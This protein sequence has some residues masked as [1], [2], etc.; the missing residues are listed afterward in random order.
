VIIGRP[1]IDSFAV[2]PLDAAAVLHKL[3]D[4]ADLASAAT[5]YQ[6]VYGE[7]VD[8]EDFADTLRDLGFVRTGE[9]AELGREATAAP[10]RWGR[11]SAV[12]LSVPALTVYAL[13]V[14]AAVYFMVRTPALRPV[15]STVYFSGSL[16]VVMLVICAAQLAGIAVHEW[17][18]VLAGRRLGLPSRLTVGRRLYF[19]VF[20]TTLLGLM[21][22]P[23]RKRILPFLAGLIADSVLISILIGLAEAGRAEG[24]P[25]WLARAC[26]GLAYVTILRVIWQAMI[27]ME[28]DL[29]HVLSSA[30]RCPDLHRM[31]VTYLRN[32]IA[33]L[34]GKEQPA[35]GDEENWTAR[36]LRVVRR[37]APVVVAGSV[38]IIG[39]AVVSV[40]P[41][42][43][44][45]ALRVYRGVTAGGL[46]T[47][48][49]WD[50]LVA[51]LLALSPFATAA[52][53][54][55]RDRRRRRAASPS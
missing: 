54:A 22:V 46:A 50:A 39:I 40:V 37:Y 4:G 28:T 19:V 45:L 41:A 24:W 38:A 35:P 53:L 27:F 8:I 25:P 13:A 18:H 11:L 49:F 43:Y 55:F 9:P 16:L 15:P 34:R 30:V 3:A 33:R 52:A 17:F 2:F 21:G 47:G 1:D 26:V 14:A 23:S 12:L 42:V 48:R 5:W 31:T 29:Y 32:L 36:E 10:V 44:D 20:E 6:D 51:G 7:P